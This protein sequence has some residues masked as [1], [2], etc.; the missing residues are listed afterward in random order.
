MVTVDIRKCPFCGCKDRRAGIR[1]MGNKGYRVVCGRCGST[2]PHVNISDFK[3]KA[4]AQENAIE[5]WNM[6]DNGI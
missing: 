1:R 3:T 4:D 5:R 6:R 2:G